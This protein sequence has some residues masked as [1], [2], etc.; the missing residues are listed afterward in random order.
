MNVQDVVI[1]E[2]MSDN[3]DNEIWLD[4]DGENEDWIELYNNTVNDINLTNYFLSDLSG[5]MH[6]WEFP[7]NTSLSRIPSGTG[8]FVS[9]TVTFSAE[10]DDTLSVDSVLSE[11]SVRVFPNPA[12]DWLNI[13]WKTFSTETQI[14]IVDIL[15]R[16]VYDTETNSNEIKIDVSNLSFGLY[17]IKMK[18]SPADYSHKI[19]IK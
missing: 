16:Q 17:I 9:T 7:E 14:T 1:N 2:F 5:F 18:N 15:G 6:K 4:Q 11:S 19:I 3:D 13:T 12:S 10:N 8:D